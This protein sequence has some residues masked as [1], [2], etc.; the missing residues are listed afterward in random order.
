MEDGQTGDPLELETVQSP[1]WLVEHQAA[2]GRE[3]WLSFGELGMGGWATV[4]AVAPAPAI[5]AGPGR[6]VLS[7]LR[8]YNEDV[9]ELRFEETGDPLRPTG[10][11]PLWSADRAAWVPAGE[12]YVGER[13]QTA[14]GVVTVA[15]VRRLPGAFKVY[16]LTVEGDHEYLVGAERVRS[17]NADKCG[18]LTGA[19]PKT[20]TNSGTSRPTTP[21]EPNSIYEQ[22]D[23]KTGDVRSRTFHDDNG[24]PF[25]RQDFDHEHG[26]LQPHEHNRQF[27]G[28]GRP[29]TGETVREVPPGYDNKPSN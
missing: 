11:H 21:N 10:N 23:P 14:D 1:D 27:D 7:T 3:V 19:A 22:V 28:S 26:G 5:A 12:V 29:V 17:H 2:P 6:V 18:G 13:L 8:R 16:N 15:E 4:Q 25:S 24:R 20:R 9:H